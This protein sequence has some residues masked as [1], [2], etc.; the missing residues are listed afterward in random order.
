MRR[1]MLDTNAVI[2]LLSGRIRMPLPEGQYSASIIT[3]IEL[4]SFSGLTQED[5]QEIQNLLLAIDRIYLTDSVRD[6]TIRLRRK[7]KLKLPDAII[8]ASALIHDAI[9]LTNDKDF[10]TIDGLVFETLP[11]LGEN[12]K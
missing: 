10:S 5:E 1:Y 8:V 6:E 9:L 7:T 4:L 12:I 2:Y 3:E 11:I